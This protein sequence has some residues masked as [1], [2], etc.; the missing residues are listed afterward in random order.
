[1]EFEILEQGAFQ[2]ALVHFEADFRA[3]LEEKRCPTGSCLRPMLSPRN[4][5]PFAE[6]F[7]PGLAPVQVI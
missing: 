7:R 6:D 4:T 1:M 2:S 5:R 3:H